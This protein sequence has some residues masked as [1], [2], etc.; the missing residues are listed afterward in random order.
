[1]RGEECRQ[2][3]E[4]RVQQPFGPSLGDVGQ[5]GGG[6]L[7][8]IRGQGKGL[9]VEVAPAYGPA[10]LHEKGIVGYREELPLHH[11]LR[12]G[13]GIPRSPVDLGGASQG[14]GVLNLAAGR[15]AVNYVGTLEVVPYLSRRNSGAGMGS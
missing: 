6:D 5:L 12:I 9:S 7:Q 10:V 3:T 2:A 13:H 11:L 1:M 14:V 4:V 15:V 8:M